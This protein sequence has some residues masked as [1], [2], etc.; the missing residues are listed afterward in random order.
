MESELAALYR[1]LRERLTESVEAWDGRAYAEFAPALTAPPYVV[2]MITAHKAL[3]RAARKVTDLT[4]RVVCVAEDLSTG[5]TCAARLFDLLDDA[6]ADTAKSLNGGY[7]WSI[8]TMTRA[9]A[10]QRT[11]LVNGMPMYE[12]G[13]VYRV[14]MEAV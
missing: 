6:D 8:L 1:A 3:A 12:T 10:S 2:Y 9:G 4:V 11:T 14:V 13:A 5:V 7:D